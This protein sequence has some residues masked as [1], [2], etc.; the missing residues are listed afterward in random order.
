MVN[1]RKTW[2]SLVNEYDDKNDLYL[3]QYSSIWFLDS[4]KLLEVVLWE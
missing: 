2:C 3:Q 1:I 4:M